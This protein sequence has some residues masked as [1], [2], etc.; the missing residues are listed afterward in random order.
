MDFKRITLFSGHYGSGK[1]NLAVNYAMLL[2]KE[3]ENVA[4]ADLDIVNPYFRTKDSEDELK[5]VG[6]RLISSEF[7]NS[8]VDLPALPADAYTMID[9]KSMY[10]VV[11][12]GGD[13]RGALALGRYSDAI[14]AENNFEML[15]V[16]NKYRP[17]TR[18][19]KSTIRVMEE[20]ESA[21][22]I[23]FTGVVNNSNLGMETTVED[24]LETVEYAEEISKIA[25][26]PVKLTSV[27]RD[28]SG[29]VQKKLENVW[30]IDIHFKREWS[31]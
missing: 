23:R 30:A 9:D 21:C 25:E 15:F 18:D 29:E 28:I 16:I 22:R 10:A 11:D 14:K 20:I 1:T 7:A 26:I 5:G 4:I 8:N 17:L 6:I 3:K 24:V 12:V 31:I 19:V 13:D 2:R 27:R